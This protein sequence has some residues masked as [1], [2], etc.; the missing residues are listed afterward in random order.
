MADL[1]LTPVSGLW[2]AY[3]V[4]ALALVFLV[5]R[6]RPVTPGNVALVALLVQQ[7]WSTMASVL[8]VGAVASDP[9]LSITATLANIPAWLLWSPLVFL[10]GPLLLGNA[11]GARTAR[12]LGTLG[13]LPSIVLLVLFALD[14]GYVIRADGTGFTDAA[15]VTLFLVFVGFAFTVGVL[16]REAL[17]TPLQV[18]RSQFALL[19]AAFSVEGAFHA[20]QSTAKIAFGLEF[21]GL[22]QAGLVLTLLSI[23]PFVA[24]VGIAGWALTLALRD[25]DRE[26]RFWARV[27]AGFIGAS[28]LTGVLASPLSVANEFTDAAGAF[29]AL[30]DLAAIALIVYAGMRYQ[31]FSLERRARQ[32]VAVTAALVIG[33]VGF[34]SL[35]EIAESFLADTVLFS[36]LPASGVFAALTVGAVSIPIGRTSLG[37]AKRLFPQV[38]RIDYEHQRKLQI[39]R[40]ALEGAFADGIATPR[41]AAS[42]RALR[43][44]LELDEEA[45]DELELQVRASLAAAQRPAGAGAAA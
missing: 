10:A 8:R 35:Q 12:I 39:Y 29:H 9:L 14:P 42:L 34:N 23:L 15:A 37:L 11:P 20:A 19:A 43:A 32:S 1:V 33:F 5:L 28:A 18:R 27:T 16:A 38:S 7:A 17:T 13:A 4:A 26:R 44:S 22:S 30:W 36:G 40:A 3:A 41:E 45:H 25:Q 2:V 21:H 24:F 6:A 31:L